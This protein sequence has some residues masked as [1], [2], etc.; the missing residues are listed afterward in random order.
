MKYL[1]VYSSS[2]GNTALLAQEIQNTFKDDICLYNGTVDMERNDAD[3]I[4]VGFWTYK[5]TCDQHMQDYLKTLHHQKIFFFGTAGFGG[6]QQYFDAILQRVEA[7]IDE[8]NQVIGRFM[9]QGKMPMS[10]KEKYTEMAKKDP[11]RFQPMIE[12]FDQALSH[13]SLDD[14]RLLTN[15]LKKIS[16]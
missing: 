13:P 15:S 9:C 7:F 5:G 16:F 8:S 10:V 2:T 12:N 14:L 4:F 11:Q 1:I 3:I 6:S